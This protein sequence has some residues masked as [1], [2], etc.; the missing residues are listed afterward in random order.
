MDDDTSKVVAFSVV[1][2]PKVTSSNAMGKE[3]FKLCT[4]SE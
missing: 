2:V 1:Q 4:E 3:G